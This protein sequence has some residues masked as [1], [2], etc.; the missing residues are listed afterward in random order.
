MCYFRSWSSVSSRWIHSDVCK[1]KMAATYSYSHLIGTM[2]LCLV[3]HHAIRDHNSRYAIPVVDFISSLL[4]MLASENDCA[5]C[6]AV[7]DWNDKPCAFVPFIY[8]RTCLR[9]I[10]RV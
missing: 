3:G 10:R 2:V 7:Q 9:F 5:G 4:V 1:H 6:H 8:R